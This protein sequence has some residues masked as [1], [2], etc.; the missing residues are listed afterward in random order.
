MFSNYVCYTITKHFVYIS[1]FFGSN[2]SYLLL[3]VKQIFKAIPSDAAS[4]LWGRDKVPTNVLI[5]SEDGRTFNVSLTESKGKYFF[6]HG[7][8]NVVVHLTLKKGCLVVLNPVDYTIF[9]LTYFIDGLSRTS[10]RT[11]LVSKT[12]NFIVRLFF[13]FILSVL[14]YLRFMN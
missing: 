8:S 4:K 10:F 11:S 6:F 13:T 3:I 14:I 5:E 2:L 1:Q 9:K 12:S 7:W